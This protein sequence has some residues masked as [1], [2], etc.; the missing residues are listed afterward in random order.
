MLIG[1]HGKAQSGKSTVAEHLFT[2]GFDEMTF[3]YPLKELVVDLFDLSWDQVLDEEL[4]EKIDLRYGMSPRRMLQ[5]LGTDVFR[6]MYP[7][8]WIDHLVRRAKRLK[9]TGQ[10]ERLVVSDVRFKNEK[11][12]IEKEGGH[13]WKIVRGNNPGSASGFEGHASE[14]DLD[15]VPDS[16]FSAVLVAESGDIKGLLGKADQEVSKLLKENQ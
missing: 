13:V 15:S 8:I 16:D 1:L 14:C 11:E 7:N 6:Q 10:G 4:K 3:A 5:H 2:H 12:A 9:K